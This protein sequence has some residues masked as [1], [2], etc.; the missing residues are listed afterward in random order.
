VKTKGKREKKL[1]KKINT[2]IEKK[3]YTTPQKDE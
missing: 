3:K 1:S 2:N